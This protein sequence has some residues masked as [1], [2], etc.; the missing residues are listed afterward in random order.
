MKKKEMLEQAAE[1]YGIPL[2]PEDKHFICRLGHK[3]KTTGSVCL[4]THGGI[5][6]GICPRCHL[7]I[8]N[9]NTEEPFW[10]DDE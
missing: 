8:F 10:C 2:W 9:G 6:N 1:Y 5:T 4:S 3:H 7:Q